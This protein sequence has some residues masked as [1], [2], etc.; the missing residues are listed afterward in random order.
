MTDTVA[1][2][3]PLLQSL[4]IELHRPVARSDA[5]RLDAL[6]HADFIEIGRS[7][8]RYS[9]ADIIAR[10]VEEATH[11]IVVSDRFELR[12]LSDDLALLNYRS[13]HACADGTLERATLRSSLW[14]RGAEGW[15]MRFHQG[16]ATDPF[17]AST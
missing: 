13:A 2:L 5:A 14:E 6:L 3:L 10:L 4:E 11:A 15:Q 17:D 12:V 1:T 7:G 16:T 9:K 8:R